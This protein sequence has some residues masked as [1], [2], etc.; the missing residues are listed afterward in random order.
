RRPEIVMSNHDQGPPLQVNGRGEV[1]SVGSRPNAVHAADGSVTSPPA[2]LQS[3]WKT[4]WPTLG[5]IA[6]SVNFV[7]AGFMPLPQPAAAE[8]KKSAS[9]R[10]FMSRNVRRRGAERHA[11]AT[12][13]RR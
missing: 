9:A 6:V 4:A 3:R 8:S 7:P 10:R 1:T 12:S 13:P 2:G 11:A 5:L